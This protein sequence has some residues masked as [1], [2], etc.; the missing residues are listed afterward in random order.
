MNEQELKRDSLEYHKKGR[1][2][3][4]EVVSTKS[5]LSQRELSLAYTPGVAYP[6]LAIKDDKDAVWDYTARGNFVA[7]VSDGSA[8]LGLGDIGPDAAMPVMEGKSVLFKT[9]ADVDAFPIC[10]SGVRDAHGKTD[11]EKLITATKQLEPTFGGINLEDIASPA[12][13][14]VESRLKREMGIPVF[15][16]DQHGTAII[17]L[18]GLLN[19][20]ELANKKIGAIRVVFNGAGAAGIACAEYY[21][22]AGVKKQNLVLCDTAGVVY[23]G[24]QENMNLRKE[25]LAS[26]TDARTLEDAMKGADVFVGVSVGN[27]VTKNMVSSMTDGAIVYAMANPLP[28]ISPADAKEAGALVVGTGRSDYP[29]Q[30]N[31]VLGFPGIFR[32]V[33]DCRAGDINEAM[34]I[35]ASKALSEVAKEAIPRKTKAFLAKAYQ[36]DS[37]AGMFD[38]KAPMKADYVIP[39]PLDPRVVPR[40]A[41]YVAEAAMKSKVARLKIDDLDDYEEEV[42]KRACKFAA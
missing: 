39:K 23:K 5:C 38:G 29:N 33:L 9:F 14:E 10:L 17:S 42:T 34:K 6:S 16:D 3:K 32:G 8:V 20:L 22:S 11:A 7:V 25:R 36:K 31:N 19:G 13:F 15:H 1:K 27:V 4:I 12:C 37:T 2:G 21:V 18:A 40:V 30:V 28:E 24:R 41:R 26:E 35:G